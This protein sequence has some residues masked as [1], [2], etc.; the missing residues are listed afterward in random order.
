[1]DGVVVANDPDSR[2][3]LLDRARYG[4]YPPGSTFKLLVGMA[5]LRD[6]R[7]AA[8]RAYTCGRLPD[9]RVGAAIPGW[10]RP[11]RDD[12]LDTRP[13][14][15][16]GMHDAMV[17]SCN[18][19]FAQL[20]VALGPEPMLDTAN[21]FRIRLTRDGKD[22]QGAG[23]IRRVSESMPQVGYGQAQVVASPLRLASVAATIAANGILR[24]P[25]LE[26]GSDA[27]AKP[28]QVVSAAAARLLAGYLRDVVVG[29]TGRSLRTHPWAIAGKT[30][31]AEV[32]GEAS[33]SWFV[34]FAPFGPATRRV[35]FAI[36]IENAGY[37]GASAAPAAGEIVSAAASAGLIA[38]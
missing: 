17:H 26:P 22:A 38:K 33:H 30:G 35:A 12:V 37:G 34:G 10:G 1:M 13:H 5:A 19:Y 4:V 14:G 6:P 8:S 20:A 24:E 23:P 29:G 9:G 18:A 15:T 16:I 32:A 36:V 21:R 31:T 2:E 27:A 7:R 3:A 28:A 25:H 11:I